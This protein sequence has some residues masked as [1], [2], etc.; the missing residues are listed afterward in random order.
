MG[1]SQTLLEHWLERC[2]V[3]ELPGENGIAFPREQFLDGSVIRGISDVL[4][5]VGHPVSAWRWLIATDAQPRSIP[6]SE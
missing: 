3:I 2:E 5:I 1:I 4:K 6:Q